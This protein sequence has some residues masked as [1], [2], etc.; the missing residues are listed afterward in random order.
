MMEPSEHM[1]LTL[2]VL[3]SDPRILHWQIALAH[4]LDSDEPIA[5]R[6]ILCHINSAH[7]SFAY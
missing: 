6:N 4:F 3:N 1:C 7:T 2:K 5:Q